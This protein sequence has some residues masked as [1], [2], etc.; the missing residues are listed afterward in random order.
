[1]T[2][3][4]SAPAS[5]VG[6]QPSD[7]PDGRMTDPSAPLAYHASLSARQAKAEGLLT[8]AANSLTHSSGSIQSCDLTR[9]LANKLKQHCAMT[10]STLWRYRWSSKA[11]PWGR[12]VFRLVALGHRIS[13]SGCTGWPTPVAE[14]N[15]EKQETVLNRKKKNGHVHIK[16]GTMAEMMFLKMEQA[17]LTASGQTQSGS[18]AATERRGRLNPALSRWLMGFRKE[19]CIAAINAHKT[20][21]STRKTRRKQE[22]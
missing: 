4:T 19:W 10:G 7:S 12:L 5:A 21:K 13:G 17:P 22:L 16:L 3:G 9:S 15:C 6:Q 18:N 20:L 14:E 2:N 11:T 8:S 1:M